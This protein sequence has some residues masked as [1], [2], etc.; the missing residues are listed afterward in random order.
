M[1]LIIAVR[2]LKTNVLF[3]NTNKLLLDTKL[4]YSTINTKTHCNTGITLQI[5]WQGSLKRAT[6]QVRRYHLGDRFINGNT[7]KYITNPQPK[8]VNIQAC[9]MM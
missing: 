6:E 9:V 1:I 3:I 4:G 2:F 7:R 8:L 5:E